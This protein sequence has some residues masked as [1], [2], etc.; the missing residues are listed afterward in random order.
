MSHKKLKVLK[1]D[2]TDSEFEEAFGCYDVTEEKAYDKAKM[3]FQVRE[4]KKQ[5]KIN[6][7][8]VFVT[9]ILAISTIIFALITFFK[10]NNLNI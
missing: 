9:W 5:N 7:Q 3:I 8:L 4:I 10:N 1:I 2:S 6:R